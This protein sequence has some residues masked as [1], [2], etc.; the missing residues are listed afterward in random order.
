MEHAV[1]SSVRV[2]QS[3]H[4]SISS[5]LNG[6]THFTDL[7]G[8]GWPLPDARVF[9]GMLQY[10][11]LFAERI[12]HPKEDAFLFAS[13]RRRT[14]E[15]D[16]ALDRLQEDHA[17]GLGAMRALEQAFM[18]Y[19]EGGRP[20]FDAFAREVEKYAT[21]YREHMRAEE[22]I[23]LP[24]AQSVLSEDDWRCIDEAFE[25]NDDPLASPQEVLQLEELF[26]RILTISP[27]P[28]GTGAR[29]EA[30]P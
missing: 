19:E 12:H 27:A 10:L 9:R 11:D 20:F 30:T 22:E 25:K 13:V 7:A 5:V 15:V 18:R 3:E 14:H 28:I 17:F 8:A 6:L 4:R 1:H 23:I 21:F 16:K 24:F 2:I 26:T 29:L